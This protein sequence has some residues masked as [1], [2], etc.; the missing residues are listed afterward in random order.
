MITDDLVSYIETQLQK[1][2]PREIITSRL[3]QAGW[4]PLDIEEGFLAIAP[5]SS[6]PLPVGKQ[7]EQSNHTDPYRE[8]PKIEKSS[9]VITQKES[10]KVW[11]P[12]Q[13]K[14]VVQES[15]SSQDS[16]NAPTSSSDD[17]SPIIGQVASSPKFQSKVYVYV[18]PT[19]DEKAT[20]VASAIKEDLLPAL[21]PKE[22]VKGDTSLPENV[23]VV[24]IPNQPKIEQ[25]ET[26]VYKTISSSQPAPVSVSPKGDFASSITTPKMFAEKSNTKTSK[27][28]LFLIVAI[29]LVSGSVFAFTKGIIS[30]PSFQF[31]LIK[32]DPKELLLS[33]S[34]ILAR[35]DS[36]KTATQ[37]TISSPLFSNITSGLLTGESVPSNERD[38]LAFT[39]LGI[40]NNKPDK[41]SIYNITAQ[42]SLFS[43]PIKMSYTSVSNMTYVSMPDL[44]QFFPSENFVQ[45]LVAIPKGELGTLVHEL[46][47]FFNIQLE[48]SDKGQI[49]SKGFSSSM[50]SEMKRAFQEFVS[51]ISVN[52]KIPET[53]RG[54]ET[55][56]YN[57]N[58]DR[59]TTK[60][61]LTSIL[62]TS[63]IAFSAEAKPLIEEALG[64]VS[65]NSF[66]IWVGKS[67][68]T[69]AQYKIIASVPLSKVLGLND[70][71]IAGNEVTLEWQTTFY[72]FDTTSNTIS[73]PENSTALPLFIN[74]LRDFKI[75]NVLSSFGTQAKSLQ[76]VEGSYGL[77]SNTS[78]SCA[79]PTQ[80]S[81]FSPVGHSTK[82][83]TPVGSIAQSMNVLLG[84]TAYPPVC[85]STTRAWMIAVPFSSDPNSIF[86][87]D[88]TGASKTL[89]VMPSG[90]ACK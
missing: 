22:L 4:N 16:V 64:S 53:I 31:S 71:G 39:I 10:P 47:P 29:L 33:M 26:P 32:K 86:C 57:I 61:L 83:G 6:V 37:V 70:N 40:T 72:D 42:S 65:V 34:S 54:T 17:L 27:K 48:E 30:V 35:H 67:S 66:E 55:Y 46:P 41:R 2:T 84:S 9:P 52:E 50:K 36:Y 63:K 76:K 1:N 60:K 56:H 69:I 43:Q 25:K 87:A 7:A 3:L 81:L 12:T 23:P 49:L 85:H 73:V 90:T 8:S 38:S 62:R 51:D 45:G 74:T 82:A 18:I 89:Q 68:G 80:S 88:S 78:G 20:S 28:M 24:S 59:P 79:S 58:V 44:S 75:K 14:P 11:I 5:V 19:E 13:V 77:K 21:A 15:A